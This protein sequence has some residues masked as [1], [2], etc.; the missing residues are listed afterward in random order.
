MPT[1]DY[2]C[3]TCGHK[4]EAKQSMKDPHLTECPQEGCPGPVK[5]KIGAG[6]GFIFKG[7]GFYI[8]DYRSDSYK[9]AAKK[10]SE[11]ASASTPSTPPPA[12]SSSSSASGT[13]STPAKTGTAA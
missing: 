11:S 5:R 9:A 3:Q 6:A 4:F 2:E 12:T 13:G 7:N 10:D 1:Y 8:T